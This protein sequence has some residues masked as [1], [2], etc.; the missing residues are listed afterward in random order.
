M[1]ASMAMVTPPAM[2]PPP[3]MPPQ[4]PPPRMPPPQHF[5]PPNTFIPPQSM[6]GPHT[7]VA[8]YE[9]PPTFF[10]GEPQPSPFFCG[11]AHMVPP[12]DPPPTPK[13]PQPPPAFG[14]KCCVCQR[15]TSYAYIVRSHHWVC[16][17]HSCP[18][19]P[20]HPPG[21]TVKASADAPPV[22]VIPLDPPPLSADGDQ[23]SFK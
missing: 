15:F 1:P 19:A 9:E 23:Q 10:A 21:R 13:Q 16:K 14:G 6:T 22:V 11:V 12:T 7:G 2:K 18:H 5:L 20:F 3:L 8:F 17:N 4:P